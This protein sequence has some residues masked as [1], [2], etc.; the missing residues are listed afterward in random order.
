MIGDANKKLDELAVDFVSINNSTINSTGSNDI[1]IIPAAGYSVT[2]DNQV[3]VDSDVITG[4]ASIT[5][6]AVL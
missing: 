5:T 3:K 4:V 1:N 2:L 6:G